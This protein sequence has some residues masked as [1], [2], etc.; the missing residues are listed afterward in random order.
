[1]VLS[2]SPEFAGLVDTFLY[3][4]IRGI[5]IEYMPVSLTGST[6]CYVG[7]MRYASDVTAMP[8]ILMDGN[9]MEQLVDFKMMR[10]TRYIKK[11]VNLAKVYRKTAELWKKEG[12]YY[13]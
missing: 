6:D 9:Y 1:M 2:E 8:T 13:D 5:K 12:E 4:R 10:G 3:W 7:E 11:Y